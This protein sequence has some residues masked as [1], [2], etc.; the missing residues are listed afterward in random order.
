M[1][2]NRGRGDQLGGWAVIAPFLFLYNLPLA[3]E[4]GLLIPEINLIVQTVRLVDDR[5]DYGIDDLSAVHGN[6]DVVADFGFVAGH[7]ARISRRIVCSLTCLAPA[8]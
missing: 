2:L 4:R 7:A 3:D 6:A 8:T 1:G 5:F